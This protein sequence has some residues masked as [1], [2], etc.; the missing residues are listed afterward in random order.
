VSSRLVNDGMARHG[1]AWQ[2]LQFL[3]FRRY[4]VR[5]YRLINFTAK[6]SARVAFKNP[7]NRVLNL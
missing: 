1:T 6:Y 3:D 5:F 7:Q 4:L 2:N